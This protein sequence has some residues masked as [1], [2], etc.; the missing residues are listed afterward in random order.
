MQ[1]YRI[2]RAKFINDLSGIGARQYGGR[3]N[4]K[5]T[6]IIYTSESRALAALEYMVHVPLL[7]TVSFNLCIATIQIPDD[8]IPKEISISELPNNWRDYPVPLTLAAIGTNWVLANETLL[9]R[10]PSAVIE[11]EYNILINPSHSDMKHVTIFDIRS[12]T[13]DVRLLRSN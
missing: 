2:A 11:H 12:F 6:N 9:L 7:L 8:I 5:G 10:V 4:L 13:F 3:W 1:V